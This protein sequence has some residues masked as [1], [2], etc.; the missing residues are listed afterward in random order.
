MNLDSYIPSIEIIY[1]KELRDYQEKE[2]Y[3][4]FNEIK[5]KR[6]LIIATTAYHSTHCSRQSY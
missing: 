1:Q 2:E 6:E 3:E 4:K 5:K